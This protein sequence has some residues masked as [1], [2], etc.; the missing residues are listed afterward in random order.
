MFGVLDQALHEHVTAQPGAAGHRRDFVDGAGRVGH[1][2]SGRELDALLAIGIFD[3]QFAALVLVGFG[4][5]QR[6]R[7]I[8][9][10][11]A[12][13][14]KRSQPLL[15]CS[16]RVPTRPTAV[17][18]SRIRPTEPDG[19]RI[20]RGNIPDGLLLRFSTSRSFCPPVMFRFGFRVTRRS[21]LR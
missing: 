12:A 15:R 16:R 2:A 18:A 7:D 11:V 17:P 4:Q 8:G 5:K 21:R 3:A 19:F 6:G 10:Q 13:V 20:G 1:Q 14:G 9:A